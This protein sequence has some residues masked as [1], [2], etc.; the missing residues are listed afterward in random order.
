MTCRDGVGSLVVFS[1]N[2]LL[3]YHVLDNTANLG[4][5]KV[6]QHYARVIRTTGPL[7]EEFPDTLRPTK[8]VPNEI[9][10]SPTRCH[11]TL[12]IV[13]LSS[14]LTDQPTRK[15]VVLTTR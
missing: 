4:S 6:L 11:T 10:I 15:F 2:V 1:L 9:L 13:L 5:H 3:N 7:N 14:P 12:S 8:A